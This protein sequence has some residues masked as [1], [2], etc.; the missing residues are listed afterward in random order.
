MK[1]RNQLY[2]KKKKKKNQLPSE[3]NLLELVQI[4]A[5]VDGLRRS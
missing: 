1:E 4:Y 2:I 3:P 5:H